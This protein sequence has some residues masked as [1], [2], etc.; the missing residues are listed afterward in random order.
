MHLVEQKSVKKITVRDIVEACGITRNTFYYYFHDIYEVLEFA[1]AAGFER[2]GQE[3]EKFEDFLSATFAFCVKYQKVLYNLYHSVGYEPLADYL[4]K[5]IRPHLTKHLQGV[6]GAEEE[7]KLLCVLCEEALVGI[8]MRWVCDP[9]R[10]TDPVEMQA[11]TKQIIA[12]FSRALC[13][14]IPTESIKEG[15][16]I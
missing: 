9:R 6:S 7:E 11:A 4:K 15:E 5:Q 14:K 8:L 12:C 2:L 1:L 3:N 16:E 10:T 13:R